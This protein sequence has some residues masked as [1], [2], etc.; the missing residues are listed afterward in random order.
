M[1]M[2]KSKGV[3]KKILGFREFGVL[4]AL[5]ILT[6]VFALSSPTFLTGK[7]LMNI[8]RQV[9][10]NALIAI[11]MTFVIITGGIDLSVGSVVALSGI[12][13]ASAMVD[14]QLPVAVAVVIG[15]IIGA[16]TG[17]VNGALITFLNM[18]PFITTMGTMTILRGLGYIYTRG[19]P[20]Y[21]VP[22]AFKQIGQGYLGA[23]PIPTVILIAVAIVAYVIL[24]KTVFG[25]HI[26]AIGGNREAAKLTGIRVK[27]VNLV[28]YVISG[29]VCGIAAVVQAARIGSGLP[30]V[31]QGYELDAIAAVIIGGAAMTGGSGTVVGTILGAVI[32][33][34][35]SNGL[36][37]LEVDSYVMQVISGLVVI[38]AVLIDGLRVMTAKRAQIEAARQALKNERRDG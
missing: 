1:S 25:R 24:R 3:L 15:V 6:A 9:S 7:N 23:L 29:T 35:L 31:G 38:V 5:L 4:M 33:G 13:T 32:L 36:S 8:T 2:G 12:I 14:F 27:P 19:Y 17:L 11:G 30:T 20:I 26:Y 10:V 18:P 16:L 28:V 37:L 34:V 21:N 22:K